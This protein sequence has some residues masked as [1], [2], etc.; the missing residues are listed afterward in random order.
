MDFHFKII[1]YL[2][3]GEVF[4]RF[5]MLLVR[6]FTGPLSKIPGPFH[7]RFT[8]ISW[9]IDSLL[10]EQMNTGENL[11]KKYGEVVRIG[12]PDCSGR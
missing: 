11:V 8:P 12:K 1:I 3:S 5:V 9:M 4:R 10:G 6:G 2:L 7:A